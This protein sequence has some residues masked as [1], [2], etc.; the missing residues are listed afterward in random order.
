MFGLNCF[1]AGRFDAGSEQ[2][3]LEHSSH[4]VFTEVDRVSLNA[5]YLGS[6]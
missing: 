6:L 4:L 1:L 3:S 5:S 2:L